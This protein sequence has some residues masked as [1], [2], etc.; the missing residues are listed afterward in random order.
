M[1]PP[2][3][4]P[5]VTGIKFAVEEVPESQN[6]NRALRRKNSSGNK[7][8]IGDTMLKSA[9]NKGEDRKEASKNFP[10][11]ILRPQRHPYGETDQPV[12]AD[13]HK[14]AAPQS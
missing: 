8:H 4:F 6:V 13:T 5:R 7:K 3:I 9:E 11:N 10:N 2:T 12:A 14:N 1:A